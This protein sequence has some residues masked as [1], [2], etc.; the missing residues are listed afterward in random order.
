VIRDRIKKDNLAAGLA[1]R[2][3]REMTQ[4][5]MSLEAISGDA[6]KKFDETGM[7]DDELAE[8]LKHAA[9]RDRRIV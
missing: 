9:R 8:L 7:T 4:A 6:Q 1:P 5:P 3:A 2:V